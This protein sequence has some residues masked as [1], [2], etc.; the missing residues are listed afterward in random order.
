[1]IDTIFEKFKEEV[2]KEI[3]TDDNHEVRAL[4][5]ELYKVYSLLI[6]LTNDNYEETHIG[7]KEELLERIVKVSSSELHK[8]SIDLGLCDGVVDKSRYDFTPNDFEFDID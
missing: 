5:C 6:N 1:M 7:T 2:K 4:K 8:R 3:Q